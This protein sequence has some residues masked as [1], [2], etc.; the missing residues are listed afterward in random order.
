MMPAVVQWHAD[1]VCYHKS[2][3]CHAVSPLIA[4][5]M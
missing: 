1:K 2:L 5:W 3:S 4:V